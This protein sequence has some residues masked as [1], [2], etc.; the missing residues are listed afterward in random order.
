M[1]MNLRTLRSELATLY[2]DKDAVR[3][4]AIDSGID[5]AHIHFDAAPATLWQSILDAAKNQAKIDPII[6]VVK[7]DFSHR[8][9]IVAGLQ[10]LQTKSTPTADQSSTTSTEI[11]RPPADAEEEAFLRTLL[12]E[13]KRNYRVLMTQRVTHGLGEEPHN[14]M[15]KL[16]HEE[17]KMNHLRMRLGIP[18]PAE[19]V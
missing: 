17:R 14:L 6:A 16:I 12:A 4:L 18:I 19:E 9:D 7:D 13:H 2:S 10:N 1:T 15:K 11:I 8:E 5:I 3:I